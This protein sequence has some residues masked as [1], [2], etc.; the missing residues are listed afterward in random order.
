[1]VL[2]IR[3][4]NKKRPRNAEKIKLKKDKPFSSNPAASISPSQT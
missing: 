1:M 2:A 4:R 3:I